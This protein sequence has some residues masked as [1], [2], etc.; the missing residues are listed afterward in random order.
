MKRTVKLVAIL[1]LTTTLSASSIYT[2][3]DLNK[4]FNKMQ[5]YINSIINSDF[6]AKYFSDSNFPKINMSETNSSYILKF[7]LAGVPKNDIKLTINADNIL[8][9]IGERKYENSDEN[10]S[11]IKKEIFYGKFARSIKLPINADQKKLDTKYKNGILTVTI[12]KKVPSKS[13][14]KVIEI[15]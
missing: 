6:K 8:N 3:Q 1:A 12:G 14:T 13:S 7:D 11:F 4:D 15:K 2:S 5:S 9:I 10:Q